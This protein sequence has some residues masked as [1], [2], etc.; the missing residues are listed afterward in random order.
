MTFPAM[1][2]YQ[3]L[4][5]R[6]KGAGFTDNFHEYVG[7]D[8]LNKRGGG[9]NFEVEVATLSDEVPRV[10]MLPVHFTSMY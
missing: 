8:K 7:I 3:A 1:K 2:F 4:E 10:C 6:I 9:C 5:S